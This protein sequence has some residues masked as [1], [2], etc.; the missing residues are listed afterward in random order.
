MRKATKYLIE[1]GSGYGKTLELFSK[2]NLYENHHWKI[3]AFE[4]NPQMVIKTRERCAQMIQM[5][6]LEVIEKAL[7][8]ENGTID[9]YIG[10]NPAGSS[11]FKDKT[12]GNL[13]KKNPINVTCLYLGDWLRAYLSKDDYI[14][15]GMNI[16]GAEYRL[17]D[18]MI[19]DSSAEYINELYVDFHNE[20]VGVLSEIDYELAERLK[21]KGVVV[22]MK[23]L[24]DAIRQGLIK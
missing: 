9:L 7:W 2:T 1:C 18:K 17:L 13:D 4:A 19:R 24:N 10:R 3:Y 5:Q 22:M 20:K 14:V 23:T 6:V 8:I 21:S 15:I 11:L 12:T 16:E